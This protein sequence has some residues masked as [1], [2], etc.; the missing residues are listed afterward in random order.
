MEL[1]VIVSMILVNIQCQRS[2]DPEVVVYSS[3][4][5][6]D[7]LTKGPGLSFTSDEESS[8]AVIKVDEGIRFQK[9]DGFGATFNEAGMICL[10]SLNFAGFLNS[11]DSIILNLINNGEETEC[12]ISWNNKMAVQKFKAHSITTVMWNKYIAER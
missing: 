8:L 12:K 1:S 9:I 5:D 10:N 11:D 7:R 4:Q 2:I 3:S 6:G